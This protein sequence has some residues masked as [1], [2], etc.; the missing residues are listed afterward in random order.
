MPFHRFD[1]CTRVRRGGNKNRS[2]KTGQDCPRK[3]RGA[4]KLHRKATKPAA[5]TPHVGQRLQPSPRDPA[6]SPRRPALLSCRFRSCRRRAVRLT[7]RR[8]FAGESTCPN[9]SSRPMPA[10]RSSVSIS[11]AA[12]FTFVRISM[13]QA[14]RTLGFALAVPSRSGCASFPRGEVQG[15][16]SRPCKPRAARRLGVQ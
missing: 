14:M 11:S 10:G 7:T 16:S 8:P 15:G 5:R 9:I 12:T 2:R 13:L 6:P 1:R 3:S 4:G